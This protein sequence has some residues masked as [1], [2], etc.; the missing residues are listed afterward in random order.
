MKH[1]SLIVLFA[2]GPWLLAPAACAPTKRDAEPASLRAAASISEPLRRLEALAEMEAIGAA[3]RDARLAEAA[4]LIDPGLP[5]AMAPGSAEFRRAARPLETVLADLPILAPASDIPEPSAQDQSAAARLYARARAAR[6]E[7]DP[8]AAAAL[9]EEAID[10]DPGS[11]RLWQ[12]LGETRLEA[13]DRDGGVD[14]LTMAAE[15]GSTDARVL[16]TLASEAAS[17]AE[18]PS[19]IRWAGAYW[20]GAPG[21]EDPAQRMVAGAVLGPAL[22][23]EGDLLAGAE[24]LAESLRLLDNRPPRPGDPVELARL[25]ARRADLGLRLGDAWAALG[26][27]ERAEAAYAATVAIQERPPVGLVSRRISAT[28][29]SGRPASGAVEMLDHVRRA[30]GDLG[31][32]EARWMRG[33]DGIERVGPALAAALG[34]MAGDADKPTTAR[35]QIL[36]TLVRGLDEP[37]DALAFIRRHPDL[38]RAETVASDALRKIVSSQRASMAAEIIRDDPAAAVAWGTA[39]VRL[40]DEP[41]A[42]TKRLIAATRRE[43]AALGFAM[44]AALERPDLAATLIDRGPTPGI[45]PV[46]GARLAG[47]AGRWDRV[48]AWLDAARDRSG[49]SRRAELLDTLLA[50]QRLDEAESLASDIDADP[51]ASATDLFIAAELALIKGNAG[52]GLERLARASAKDPFDER[53]W[54][55]RIG[56]RTGESTLADE[57]EAIRIGR[58]ISELRPRGSLFVMLRARDL[59]GQGMIREAAELLVAINER[60][61]ARDNG[62]QLLVQAARATTQSSPETA[63][64]I[65]DWLERRREAFPGSVGVAL[66]KAQL[67]AGMDDPEGAFEL[68]DDAWKRIGHPE[69]ARTAEALLAQRLE[70]GDEAVTRALDRLAPPP[71][72]VN[73]SLE[74]AEAAAT[75]ARWSVSL[76]AARAALPASGRLS[77][78]QLQRWFA[79]AFELIRSAESSGLAGEVI[80]LLDRADG[81]G[82]EM[83]DELIRGRLLLLARSGDTDRLFAFVRDEPLGPDSGFIAVQA[84]LGAERTTEALAL[85]ADL[86]LEGEGVYEDAFSEWVRMA[87]LLGEAGDVRTVTERLRST[88]RDAE[89]AAI[90]RERFV[91]EEMPPGD[92]PTRDMADI[93]YI[94]GLIAGF[95]ERDDASEGMLRLALEYDPR[96]AWA[97][98]DLGY[99]LADRGASLDEAERLLVMAYEILPDEASVTDSIGWVRY[100]LGVLEDETDDDGAVTREGA[101]T[102]LERAASMEDGRENATILYHLGDALW[103]VG[104]R[105]EALKFWSEAEAQLRREARELS[106]QSQPDSRRVDRVNTRLREVRRRIGDAE[107]G[108]PPAVAPIPSLDDPPE[109]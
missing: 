73:A 77:D 53:V 2:A 15:L 93:A 86:A 13:R 91:P 101:V 109:E 30:A 95:F 74:R 80:A 12:E 89:A 10:L 1:R 72:G 108:R 36:R 50:C 22:L 71:L 58:E 98:N 67:L 39:L 65:G 61:P 70:R 100:K 29:A 78:A 14:A 103:R 7:G 9:L 43:Q 16:L 17:R 90:A 11:A 85:L 19:V 33:F 88:G 5:V 104:R 69:L 102:L 41:L 63:G 38:A 28:V 40:Q 60:E 47:L 55:R 18:L 25:R 105:D 81:M 96:H 75:G 94:A 49:P 99:Q 57:N 48:D 62:L 106:T 21:S 51:D 82:V 97:A 92:H 68:A 87:G 4:R 83:P 64:F 8:Q 59:G 42:E 26:R 79:V 20:A 34:A 56:L 76:D 37:E 44:A 3:P 66:A 107:A 23:E 35:R 46:L 54:E 6:A 32:E 45:D 27:L 84:L 52:L 31:P 24:V